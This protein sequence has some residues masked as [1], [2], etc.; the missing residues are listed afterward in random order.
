MKGLLWEVNLS[1]CPRLVKEPAT[2]ADRECQVWLRGYHTTI[3]KTIAEAV[4][5]GRKTG[6]AVS[7]DRRTAGTVA[8]SRKTT[9]TV[10]VFGM[11]KG[12][13]GQARAFRLS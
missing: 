12:R 10:V 1:L 2:Q 6:L 4:S 7:A 13:G 8:A 9:G 5:D 11:I 3:A